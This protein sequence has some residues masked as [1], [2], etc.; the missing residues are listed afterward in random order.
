MIRYIFFFLLT[1]GVSLPSEATSIPTPPKLKAKSWVL[2][3]ARSGQLLSQHDPDTELPPASLTKMM[4]LYLAFEEVRKKKLALDERVEVSKKAWKIGGSRMFIEPRL[5]PTVEELLHGIAT[6]SGND[7]C[8]A[9]AEHMD[10]SEDGFAE[11]MN[12]KAKDLGMNHSHFLNATGYP[13]K[14]HYSS[15]GDMAILG[16]ALWHDFP[17][18]YK[19]FS[20]KEYTYNGITQSNRNR[21]LWS[22]PR[23]DGIKTGHTKEAGYCLVSS[24]EEK[25]TRFVAAIFGTDSDSARAKLSRQ[26]LN[27]GFRNFIS[28]QPADKD[29]RRQVE[30]FRGSENSVWLVPESP[31]SIMVPR[32]ME[33]RVAF[34]LHYDAPLLAPVHKGQQVGTIEAVV[35]E[36]DGQPGKVLATVP[37][38]AS[39]TVEEASWIGRMWDEGRLWWRNRNA[40][41]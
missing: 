26:L 18:M 31:V 22:D 14:G 21:L 5:K 16:A 24:A 15:A 30:V 38:N 25:G 11:R 9:L 33:N 19:L 34:H 4:T 6:F 27:Y 13:V 1:L 8:I 40:G 3:D 17:K 37:M 10:G 36:K 39:T 20:E 28:V 7:A 41:E 2:M 23:V 29:I 35:M 32:G 12:A